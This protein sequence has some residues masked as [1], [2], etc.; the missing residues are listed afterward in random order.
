M[1]HFQAIQSTTLELLK[2]LMSLE[3]FQKARLVGGTG[4]ALQ[5]GHRKSIDI[6]LFGL[7][8]MDIFETGNLF[9]NNF[10]V[11]IIRKTQNILVYSIDNVKVDIVN[12]G[13]PWLENPIESDGIRLASMKDIAAMKLSA[14]SGR[15][16]KK[17]FIDIFFLLKHF[18]LREL[19]KF[20]LAKYEDGS[21]FLV[22]KSLTY[23]EDAEKDEAPEMLENIYWEDIKRQVRRAHKII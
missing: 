6:D 18:T 21:E 1:L 7:I 23:F 17:D 5:I 2:Y 10:R 19:I 22:I 4:L 16:S 12:Y 8:E 9:K 3:V 13:Y 20:Y 14:I 15:G 11:H